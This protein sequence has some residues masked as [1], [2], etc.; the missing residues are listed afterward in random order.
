MGQSKILSL[1][2][3]EAPTPY[4]NREREK[5]NFEV[6]STYHFI[7]QEFKEEKRCRKLKPIVEISVED[8]FDIVFVTR[9]ERYLR[10]QI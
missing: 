1:K 6:K 2:E 3:G 7:P 9:Y 5:W 10:E 4:L 8:L